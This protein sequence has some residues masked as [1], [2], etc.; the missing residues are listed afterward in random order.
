MKLTEYT[1]F[2]L[3]VLLVMVSCE[4]PVQNDR[5]IYPVH[6]LEEVSQNM[7]Q[8]L[9]DNESSLCGCSTFFE[10]TNLLSVAMDDLLNVAGGFKETGELNNAMDLNKGNY[11]ILADSFQQMLAE[12]KTEFDGCIKSNTDNQKCTEAL[13]SAKKSLDIFSGFLSESELKKA[14]VAEIYYWLAVTK[15]QIFFL[16]STTQSGNVS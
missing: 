12:I 10:A 13:R 7:E 5:I 8:L 4:L 6:R 9:R 1:F 2:I 3:L 15:N 11:V 14:S 16:A